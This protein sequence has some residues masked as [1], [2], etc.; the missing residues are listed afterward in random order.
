[1]NAER[2]KIVIVIALEFTESYKYIL[3]AHKIILVYQLSDSPLKVLLKIY[4]KNIFFKNIFY[5]AYL[6]IYVLHNLCMLLKRN[7]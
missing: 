4:F 5:I 6:Y 3:I 2:V 1:M 7:Y